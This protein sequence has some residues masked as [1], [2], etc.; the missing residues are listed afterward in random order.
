M[1]MGK[2]D[3]R[4][5]NTTTKKEKNKRIRY[6]IKE[7]ALRKTLE[8]AIRV[9]DS[10]EEVSSLIDHFNKKMFFVLTEKQF[11]SIV[12]D[13]ERK[14]VN[15]FW[16]DWKEYGLTKNVKDKYNISRGKK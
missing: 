14:R 4:E 5:T 7:E 9:E 12:L 8:N 6:L 15:K 16:G 3:F 11:N 2:L 13:R 10:L 1:M